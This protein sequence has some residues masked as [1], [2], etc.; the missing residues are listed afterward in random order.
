MSPKPRVLASAVLAVALS[1]TAAGPA[2]AQQ[3]P[4]VIPLPA[5][6]F[7]EG[8]ATGTGT[9]VYAG[10]LATGGIW[11]GDLRTGLGSVLVPGGEGRPSVGLKVSR[12]LI[13]VAGGPS[14]VISVYNATTGAEVATYDT[15]APFLNDVTITNDAAWFTD[16]FSPFLYRLP[17]KAG[18]PAG[19]P[20]AVPL[21]GDWV[22]TDGF[23]ANGIAATP[24]GKVLLV[25]NSTTGTL[26]RVDPATGSATAVAVDTPLTAGDGILLQG[27]ELSVVRNRFNEI[28]V[29]RMSSD[30]SSATLVQ[31]LTDP[32]FAV[33]TTVA[34]F[35]S[36]LYAVNARFGDPAPAS[37]EI[38]KVDGS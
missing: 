15:G 20:V 22:Q 36:T 4:E 18:Q 1:A 32:D 7:A 33:P 14:G 38:V 11:K 30:F 37:F 29:L 24:N 10:S 16:S 25:I 21:G 12:G 6:W 23:N 8:V 5:N 19:D 28:A 35:G 2:G 13:Y 27:K 26:Y 17:L 3:F 34:A 9:T 31:T